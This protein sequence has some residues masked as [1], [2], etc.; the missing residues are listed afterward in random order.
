PS[1]YSDPYGW[2]SFEEVAVLFSEDE[3]SLLDRGQKALYKEVMRENYGNV[4][5]LGKESRSLELGRCR[6]LQCRAF[7]IQ[8]LSMLWN[9]LERKYLG[10][11]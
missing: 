6:I 1:G 10:L 5:S 8:T 7:R 4:A 3:W 2:I 9:H 11:W